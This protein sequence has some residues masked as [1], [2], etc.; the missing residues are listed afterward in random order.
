[1]LHLVFPHGPWRYLPD[2]RRYDEVDP[3]PG[4]VDERGRGTSWR[5]D[6]W[7]VA[8]AYQRHLLQ[9]QL[10]DKLVSALL[11]KLKRTNLLDD[12]LLVVT[13]DHGI[14]W[15]PGAWKRLPTRATAGSL[16]WVPLFVKAPGQREPYVSD[17]PAETVDVLPTIADHLD[18]TTWPGVDGISL[19]AEYPLRRERLVVD[20]RVPTGPRLLRRAV[21]EKHDLL[22]G[23]DG[24]V[25]P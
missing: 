8:Q 5:R 9:T 4:E 25:D 17:A 18:A 7:L 21:E 11:M 15:K 19:A 6:G 23:P 16:G 13:A 2:G 22:A 24:V 20:V 3:M 14:G 10:A 12:A 1:M